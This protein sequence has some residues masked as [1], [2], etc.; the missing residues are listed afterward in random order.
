MTTHECANA[1]LVRTG[2]N[3]T[4]GHRP[5]LTRWQQSIQGLQM[6]MVLALD[7]T[8]HDPSKTCRGCGSSAS[9]SQRPSSRAPHVLQR[10][11]SSSEHSHQCQKCYCFV[12]D[13]ACAAAEADTVSSFRSAESAASLQSGVSIGLA[14]IRI[15]KS[16][17]K[18]PSIALR[19]PSDGHRSWIEVWSKSR[20]PKIEK[21]KR[22]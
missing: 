9:T 12:L 19:W 13:R 2:L 7:C 17:V 1:P 22:K 10:H 8:G 4:G 6:R 18:G 16:I 21:R 5:R 3:P 11:G 20:A 15:A 14:V